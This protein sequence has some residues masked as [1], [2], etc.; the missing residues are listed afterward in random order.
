MQKNTSLCFNIE[1]FKINIYNWSEKTMVGLLTWLTEWEKFNL[2]Y[3]SSCTS[4]FVFDSVELQSHLSLKLEEL[5]TDKS[6]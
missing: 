5:N 3:K 1:L 4:L 2:L 6:S